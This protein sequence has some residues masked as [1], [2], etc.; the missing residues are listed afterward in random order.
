MIHELGQVQ[1]F[2]KRKSLKYNPKVR[3]RNLQ[4]L[5]HYHLTKLTFDMKKFL[6]IFSS[7]LLL[8]LAIFSTG[9]EEDPVVDPTGPSITATEATPDKV[10]E[11]AGTWVTFSVTATKGTVADLQAITVYEGSTKLTF[12]TQVKVTEPDAASNP[13]I[14]S[15]GTSVSY[16]ISVLVEAAAGEAHY[17]IEV[18]DKDG[19]TAS[20]DVHVEV[21][22]ALTQSLTGVLFNSAGLPGTGGL[23]LDEGTGTGSSNVEAELRDMGID[24]SS[25][26]EATEWRQRIGGINGAEVRFVGTDGVETDFNGIASKEAVIAAYDGGLDFV[27][28]STIADGGIDVWGNFKVSKKLEVGDIF[29]VYKSSSATYYLVLVQNIV[30]EPG[31][32]NN[33]DNYT[34]AIKY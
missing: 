22:T 10:V 23:D 13:W 8:S 2:D 3:N 21:E 14:V 4:A 30:V 18:S 32:N 33:L 5:N 7:A 31:L 26:N 28:A 9:C 1:A 34:F 19:L 6:W 12:D 16:E 20:A 17:D 24:S 27:A 29:A 11:G 25:T 15:N